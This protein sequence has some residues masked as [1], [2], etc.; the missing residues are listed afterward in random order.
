VALTSIATSS[1]VSGTE[2]LI[3]GGKLTIV[4]AAWFVIGM[5]AVPRLVKSVSK[6]GTDEMLTVLATGL[7]L[8]LVALAATF[9]YSVALGAFIMG[10]IIAE[11]AEAKRIEHLIAPL[12]DIFAAVFFVSVGMLLDPGILVREWEAVAVITLVIIAGK[13]VAVSIGALLT[14]QGVRI[15]TQTGLSM[16]Q[17]GEFSFIIAS[18][19][20]TY[21]VI[22]EQLYP[23]IIAASVLTTFTTPYLIKMAEPA[24]ALLDKKLPAGFLELVTN[25]SAWLQRRSHMP[26]TSHAV[27]AFIKWG[28]NAAAVIT[29]FTFAARFAVPAFKTLG[30]NFPALT[31]AWLAGFVASSPCILAM[32]NAF[33]QRE[34][35]SSRGWRHGSKAVAVL[36]TTL[37]LGLVSA[38]FFPA[39]WT[40]AASLAVCLLALVLFRKRVAVW[41]RWLEI[42]FKSGFQNDLTQPAKQKR[43]DK[44]APWDAHL[45]EIRVPPRSFLAG[46][47]LSAAGL[48]EKFNV[49]V[50]VIAREGED[51]VAPPAKETIYP[52]DR[53][54][55]FATDA[56]IELLRA[57]LKPSELSEQT[58]EANKSYI[59]EQMSIGPSSPILG[60]SIKG[61]KLRDRFDCMV[62]GLERGSH[63]IQNPDPDT[64]L[65]AGDRLWV[66]GASIRLRELATLAAGT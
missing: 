66:V 55:C 6:H 38:G 5:F 36:A 52:G 50:I 18:L 17:I 61:S 32:T 59:L 39:R 47:T 2:L 8:A 31:A 27:N 23:V 48:R 10:S 40:L 63:R 3:A 41:Y 49:T 30:E 45:V 33:K 21:K 20:L 57:A 43:H 54:L 51:I 25:Y 34:D 7:C 65:H 26:R 46:K 35:E 42:E 12:R 62:V 37:F 29:I 44:F 19:G 16:A 1:T 14:G 11:S 9:H 4:V 64:T 58:A 24:V 28:L 53:L 15:A 60:Q 22:G 13:I 56:N